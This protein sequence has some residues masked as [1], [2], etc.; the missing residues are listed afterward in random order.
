M[1][2]GAKIANDLAMLSHNRKDEE[3]ANR[4]GLKMLPTT[5]IDPAGMISFF[6]SL[7]EKDAGEGKVPSVMNHIS[8]P[9]RSN[10]LSQGMTCGF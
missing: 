5:G 10:A 2:Y 9:A 8:F 6:E 3:E 7:Q 1:V 4:E